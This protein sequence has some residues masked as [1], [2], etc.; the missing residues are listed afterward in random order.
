[1]TRGVVPLDVAKFKDSLPYI[2]VHAESYDV[3]LYRP[4]IDYVGVD[5]LYDKV[6]LYDT[7]RGV[8]CHNHSAATITNCWQTV[9]GIA[10]R[11]LNFLENHDEQRFGSEQY[12]GDPAKV[13]PSLVV[14]SM[15]STGPMMI[16][17][18]Q[19]LGEQARDAEGF[20]GYDGHTTILDYRRRQTLRCLLN[21]L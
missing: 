1:M 19:E 4:F 2:K 18:A 20:R 11:M 3:G 16:Y 9:E 14:S 7:L 21:V 17:I 5:Y 10:P 12:A 15:I 13:I 8:Q 6:H